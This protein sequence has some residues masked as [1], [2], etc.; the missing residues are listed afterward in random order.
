MS[1]RMVR[2]KIK[3]ENAADVEASAKEI[4]IA[5]SEGP[6]SSDKEATTM[7]VARTHHYSVDPADLDKLLAWRA[8][9]IAKVRAAY[10]GLAEARLIRLEDGTYRDTWRWDSAAQMQAALPA[11]AL[12]EAREALGLARD[13]SA[14]YGEIIDEQ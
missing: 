8:A 3:T 6:G 7:A 12:A 4:L 1:V 2:S 9:L 13:Y 14:D 5:V 10:P 11:T